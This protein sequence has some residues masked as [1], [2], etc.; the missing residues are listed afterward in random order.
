MF[1]K[2]T[3]KYI[4]AY[5]GL[6]K[7]VWMLTLV[8]LINRSG[9]M[10]LFFMTL[11][12]TQSLELSITYAGQLLSVYGIGALVGAYLGGWLTDLWG[13]KTVQM[14]TLILAGIGYIVLGY[15][16][17]EI[18]IAAMLFIIAI[19]AEGFRPASSAAIA[20]YAPPAMRP[21]SYAML[22]LASNLGVVV[23]PAVGGLLATVGYVYLFW[24]DGL[25][26]FLAAIVFWIFFHGRKPIEEFHSQAERPKDISPWSDKIFILT[27]I[28]IF[29]L[30]LVFTQV[31]NTWPIYFKEIYRLLES[32]IGILLAI[33]GALIVLIEMPVIHWLESKNV[34]RIMAVGTLIFYL[35]FA[36]LPLGST[37]V[38][39]AF[40]VIVWTLGEVMVFPLISS[41]VANRSNEKNRGKYMGMLTF[42][43]S[44]ALVVGP[45]LG[46]WIYDALGPSNLWYLLGLSGLFVFFGFE[47]INR[48][49]KKE[50]NS[51]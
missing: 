51:R 34:V 36:I 32:E 41:F 39:A 49:V 27:L 43:F 14:L 2:L 23:G 33:N 35:G 31:L 26:C 17:K 16:E 28:T 10:V 24:A 44:L 45:V 12:L 13:T 6:P 38:Y 7:E 1:K 20:E 42:S 19:M 48:S 18:A 25:T 22:R 29:P 4:S 15:V 3:G 5:S 37:F 46:T 30:G 11:Y 8:L 40:T 47:I 9:S 50:N 21:R